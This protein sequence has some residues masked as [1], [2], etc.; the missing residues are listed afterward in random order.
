[1]SSL[2]FA[3]ECARE[4]TNWQELKKTIIREISLYDLFYFSQCENWW[5]HEFN[6]ASH[7]R[8][9]QSRYHSPLGINPVFIQAA[10]NTIQA[11][12]TLSTPATLLSQASIRMWFA[13]FSND[14]VAKRFEISSFICKCTSTPK[15]VRMKSWLLT[16]TTNQCPIQVGRY[17]TGHRWRGLHIL[18]PSS[19]WLV[20]VNNYVSNISY[21][22]DCRSGCR[23]G[24]RFG[25]RCSGN[26]LFGG[27]H[28]FDTSILGS[29]LQFCGD[30]VGM[31]IC[32][33]VFWMKIQ[34]GNILDIQAIESLYWS[35][36]EE[37]G[38]FNMNNWKGRL[39]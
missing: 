21:F 36:F 11:D 39:Q 18:S 10:S 12:R 33:V 7:C 38:Y 17:I 24:F 14:L 8:D 2:N 19:C 31:K 15:T 1:M 29:E 32:C 22:V 30:P 13:S 4:K 3:L 16:L 27:T 20:T 35:R 6:S 23:F 37:G 28:L 34:N 26:I 9:D 5:C 25:F